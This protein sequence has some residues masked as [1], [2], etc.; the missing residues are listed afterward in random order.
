M[1]K[2]EFIALRRQHKTIQIGICR[3]FNRSLFNNTT[4]KHLSSLTINEFQNL[5]QN[6][7]IHENRKPPIIVNK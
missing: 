3:C 4:L 5:S 6:E 1:F 2:S 7:E